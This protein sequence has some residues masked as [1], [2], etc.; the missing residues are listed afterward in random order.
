MLVSDH[1]CATR[2]LAAQSSTFR[3]I[4]ANPGYHA[5]TTC[6]ARGVVSEVRGCSR[7][8][9][10]VME[11]VLAQPR[12][13]EACEV[14]DT[15]PSRIQ[16]VYITMI[17]GAALIPLVFGNKVILTTHKAHFDSLSACTP[18]IYSI[19]C[20]VFFFFM[21]ERRASPQGAPV[22]FLCWYGY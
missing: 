10:E 22:P 17:G 18:I 13:C 3:L 19:A 11:A 12:G 20:I 8:R 4:Q 16:T 15:I 6:Y 14:A 21:I 2:R 5:F 7:G 9:L 1:H